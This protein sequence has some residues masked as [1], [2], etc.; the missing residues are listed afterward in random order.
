MMRV[1]FLFIL[2]LMAIFPIKSKEIGSET[3]LE[4]PRFVSLKTNESNLR[5]GSSENYPIKLKYIKQN[6]PVKIIDEYKN[7]RKIIDIDN[8]I[9]WI[10]KRLLKSNRYGVIN[11][12]YNNL[13]Q[14]YNKPEGKIV[15]KIGKRNIVK[16]NY[17]LSEWCNSNI[18]NYKFWILKINLWGVNKN[19]K[20]DIPYYQ[21]LINQIWKIN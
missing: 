11:P 5:I 17:C 8:N 15:G 1:I 4:I 21:F 18:D 14:V 12:P 7:W 19:E 2:F 6:L 9:G 16:I 3:K 20:F 13:V 10:H